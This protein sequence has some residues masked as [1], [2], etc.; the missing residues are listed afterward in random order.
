MNDSRTGKP[1]VPDSG[2]GVFVWHSTRI[3]DAG[4]L[5]LSRLDGD[6]KPVWHTELPLSE[7][8]PVNLISTWSLPGFVAVTGLLQSKDA[9]VTSRVPQLVSIDL[10]TGEAKSTTLAR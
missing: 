6:L 8:S 1:R 3:D 2:D 7:S 5:A 9:G 4:R 10:N